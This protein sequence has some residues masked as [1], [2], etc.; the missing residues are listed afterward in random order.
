[1]SYSS[2]TTLYGIHKWGHRAIKKVGILASLSESSHRYVDF[3]THLSGSLTHLDAA[4]VEFLQK[5]YS[6]SE[7]DALRVLQAR[8]KQVRISFDKLMAPAPA[9]LAGGKSRRKP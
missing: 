5:S 3:K 1:M 4:I 9:P 7:M 6:A 8:I 2:S